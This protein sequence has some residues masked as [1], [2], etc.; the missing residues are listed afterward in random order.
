MSQL[1]T[2]KCLNHPRFKQLT[3]ARAWFSLSFSLVIAVIY[4]IYVLGM[5]YAPDL[6]ARPVIE[7]GAMT[8]GIFIAMLSIINGI[9]CAGAYTWWANRKFDLLNQELLKELGHE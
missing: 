6:M 2:E 4:G 5:S 9:I 8:Y 3:R 7:G 1:E